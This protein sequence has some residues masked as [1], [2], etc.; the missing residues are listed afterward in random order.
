MFQHDAERQATLQQWVHALR[1][2][3]GDVTAEE[4]LRLLLLK[5]C[6]R[7]VAADTLSPSVRVDAAWHELLLR[8]K[9]YVTICAALLPAGEIL[10]HKPENAQQGAHERDR[11]LGRTLD[12]YRLLFAEEPPLAVRSPTCA[13]LLSFGR[14]AFGCLPQCPCTRHTTTPRPVMPPLQPDLSSFPPC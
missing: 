6:I 1:G 5:A 2:R 12:L 9:L 13:L 14:N 8:P 10:D 3:G 11:R 7:D 4:C